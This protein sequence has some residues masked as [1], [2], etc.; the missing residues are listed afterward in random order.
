MSTLS[1]E[2]IQDCRSLLTTTTIDLEDRLETIMQ[3]LESL[4]HGKSPASTAEAVVLERMEGE[5]L[6]IE[7]AL[8]L[9][10]NLSQQIDE[11][12]RSLP[13]DDAFPRL[14]DPSPT[15][16]MLVSEGLNG[17]KEYMVFALQRLEK[18]RREVADRLNVDPAAATSSKDK[19][20]L[21]NLQNEAETLRHGLRFFSNVDSYLEEQMSNIENHAEGNDT[22]QLMVSTDGKPI[23]GKNS[24]FGDRLKQAGGHYDNLS[25]QQVSQ[26]FTT[27]SIRQ[28]ETMKDKK[29]EASTSNS[30]SARETSQEPFRGRGFTLHPKASARTSPP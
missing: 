14:C 9:C 30:K 22:I 19:V 3:K 18:H 29:D 20:L 24:G 8:Q 15:P 6:S 4:G 16:N 27:I 21:D 28:I 25:L 5:R 17:C 26:D 1:V 11:L 12:Q 10:V 2:A 23:K 13:K 7:Q